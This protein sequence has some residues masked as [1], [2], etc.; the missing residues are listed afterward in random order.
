MEDGGGL[1]I[2]AGK[3][4]FADALVY[5]SQRMAHAVKAGLRGFLEGVLPD[6]VTLRDSAAFEEIVQMRS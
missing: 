3:L 4:G 6:A 5:Q 1:K 2:A